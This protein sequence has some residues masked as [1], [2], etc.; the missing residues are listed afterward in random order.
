MSSSKQSFGATN[1]LGV[2]FR[3]NYGAD[4]DS[5]AVRPSC[6][7]TVCAAYT[8]RSMK[9]AGSLLVSSPGLRHELTAECLILP[10]VGSLRF[11]FPPAW[12]HPAALKAAMCPD[13][14]GGCTPLRAGGAAH[15]KLGE[16]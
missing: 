15:P 16:R 12:P 9:V 5:Q 14:P 8:W 7:Y 13:R 2:S 6:L 1:V 4:R 11:E 3:T 10:R